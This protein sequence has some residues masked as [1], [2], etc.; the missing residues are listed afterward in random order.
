MDACVKWRVGCG[1]F[2]VHG[3]VAGAGRPARS[4]RRLVTLRFAGR[5]RMTVSGR[6]LPRTRVASSVCPDRIEHIEVPH[7]VGAGRRAP[8]WSWSGGERFLVGGV[9][10]VAEGLAGHGGPDEAAEFTGDGGSGE[11]REF[12]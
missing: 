10:L 6:E 5:D 9:W 11:G 1:W 12:A 3:G 7:R 4:Q 2:G 8:A